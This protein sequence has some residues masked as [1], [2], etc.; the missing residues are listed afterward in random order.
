MKFENCLQ[1]NS[2]NFTFVLKSFTLISLYMRE[3]SFLRS[4]QLRGSFAIE[5]YV[6]V[7]YVSWGWGYVFV[8]DWL[9]QSPWPLECG[10]GQSEEAYSAFLSTKV[11]HHQPSNGRPHTHLCPYMAIFKIMPIYGNF[12]KK[13]IK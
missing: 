9:L 2:I 3:P 10:R 11:H 6:S 13:F 8:C 12:T 4:L 7:F 1:L 5:M